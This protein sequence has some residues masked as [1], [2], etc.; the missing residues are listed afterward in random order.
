MLIIYVSHITQQMKAAQ[1]WIQT[2]ER[3]GF[4]TQ[5]GSANQV[6]QMHTPLAQRPVL[7]PKVQ[8]SST[9]G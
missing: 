3:Q 6:V 8:E 1:S 7:Q 4:S 5:Y 2:E 9:T